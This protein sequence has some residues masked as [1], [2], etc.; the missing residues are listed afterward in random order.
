MRPELQRSSIP[1][2]AQAHNHTRGLITKVTVAPPGLSRVDVGDV[3]LDE[4]EARGQ[5]RVAQRDARVRERRGVDDYGDLRR[6]FGFRACMWGRGR[7]GREVR[8]QKVDDGAL[9]V[10]LE[11]VHVD[12]ELVGAGGGGGDD[13]RERRGAVDVWFARAEEVQVGAVDEEDF[14]WGGGGGGGGRHGILS[15]EGGGMSGGEVING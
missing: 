5:Q 8:V 3:H 9:V 15:K 2:R 1:K 6:R 13:V 11:R 12:V 4:R 14:A 10:R 7:R